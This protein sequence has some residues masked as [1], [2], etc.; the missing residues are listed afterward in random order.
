MQH[1][2]SIAAF[3]VC[4]KEKKALQYSS[5]HNQFQGLQ[6][7]PQHRANFLYQFVQF[8]QVTDADAAAVP[9]RWLESRLYSTPQTYRMKLIL[10]Y[11]FL[12][13]AL[14]FLKQWWL[15][16]TDQ[17]VHFSGGSVLVTLVDRCFMQ[18]P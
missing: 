15:L 6:S 9:N 1:K 2:E 16:F 18:S 10:L 17:L 14:S 13:L 7:S 4:P 11:P 12:P 8:V 5:Y 3:S